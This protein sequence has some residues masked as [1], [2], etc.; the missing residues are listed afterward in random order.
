MRRENLYMLGEKKQAS[1]FLIL[2]LCAV[3]NKH[4]KDCK[5]ENNHN[6]KTEPFKCSHIIRSLI[7]NVWRICK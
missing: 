4:K 1:V 2:G 7:A 6:A 3:S 5:P